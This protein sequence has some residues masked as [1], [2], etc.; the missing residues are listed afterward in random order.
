MSKKIC[1]IS[2][3]YPTN[4]DPEYA[5]IQPVARAFADEGKECIVIAPQS[6]TKH[7][8]TK[9]KKRPYRW[10]DKTNKGNVV[11]I[12]QPEYLS[13]S[14]I[15]IFKRNV[16]ILLRDCAIERCFK[17]EEIEPDVLYAHF[18]DCGIVACKLAKKNNTPVF[19]ASGESRI[20]VFNYYRKSK[21]VKS[22]PY[23]KGLV[24]V[25]TKNL[26]ESRN[27][28]LLQFNPKTLVLP[29]AIN[30]QEFYNIPKDKARKILGYKIED[31]IAIFV[32]TFCHR[33][34]VLRVIQA[35]E[36]IESLKLILIGSGEQEA[37]SDRIIFSGKVPHDK[38]YLYLNAADVFVLP[39]LAEGCCNAI[40]EALACGLPI[41]SSNLSF[42]KDILN[43]SNSIMINPENIDEIAVALDQ[44]INDEALQTILSKGAL[45]SVKEL[46]IDQRCK[47]ILAFLN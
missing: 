29:N 32:G 35:V 8:L 7:K 44:I 20:R 9:K 45:L 5:F 34:G 42:N 38:I 11:I 13:L 37:K 25:S 14:T 21:I 26:A 22:L 46:T 36:K 27:F 4:D 16:S 1:I 39:T 33:K 3:G 15:K 19:V 24:C 40:V 31:R 23:I 41:V 17:K 28:G 30:P 43:E 12:Y 47:K 18:W 6:W 10:I 2:N